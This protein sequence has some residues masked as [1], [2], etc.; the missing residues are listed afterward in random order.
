M[1]QPTLNKL[2]IGI[3]GG[4][5]DPVH[6]GHLHLANKTLKVFSLD[7]ILWVP[8]HISPHKLD[9][10]P[11]S[12]THRLNMIQC[13]LTDEPKYKISDIEILRQGVS[14]T[15]DTVKKLTEENPNA[16]FSLIMGCD[17]FKEIH[18]WRNCEE[19]LTLCNLIVSNRPG[20]QNEEAE[21]TLNQLNLQYRVIQSDTLKKTYQCP[22]T[23]KTI[24]F[25][26]IN[27]LDISSSQIRKALQNGDSL[28]KMLPP[29]VERYIME[30]RLYQK[31][32]LPEN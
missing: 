30:Y 2:N 24:S 25:F 10:K 27:P 3:L 28:K 20:F 18:N 17:T 9:Q 8:A 23:N 1:N 16:S 21:K 22:S 29:K 12:A 31:E 11:T 6:L 32:S 5:F 26:E 13:A 4:S 19:L 15:T 7:Q 14:Y